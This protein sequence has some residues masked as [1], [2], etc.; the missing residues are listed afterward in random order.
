MRAGSMPIRA[1]TNAIVGCEE[2]TITRL[3]HHFHH[4]TVAILAQCTSRAVAETQALPFS[5]STNHMQLL[6]S[7]EQYLALR[8][9]VCGL[10]IK[11]E[12]F[13]QCSA[14]GT[15]TRVAG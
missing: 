7:G 14:T 2:Y 4:T 13:G 15:R 9:N 11:A 6:Y 1:A 8:F 3:H 12:N 10:Y 5:S